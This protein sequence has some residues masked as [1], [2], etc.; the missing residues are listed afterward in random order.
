MGIS[1]F[2]I[3]VAEPVLEDLRSRLGETRWP[4]EIE[5]AGWD[6]GTHTAWLRELCEYWRDGYDWRRAESAL[7]GFAH[8]RVEVPG[9]TL[10]CIH[11]RSPHE[12]A[13]PLMLTHGWPDSVYLFHKI[14]GPLSRPEEY[15]GDAADAFHVVCPS[16]PGYGW[17]DAPRERG[18]HVRRVAEAQA[19]LMGRLGYR[20][21]GVQGGDW[22]AVISP[23]VALK[24]PD[25]VCGVHL[26]MVAA[27]P[28]TDREP[29]AETL[30]ALKRA[31]AHQQVGMGY[32]MIQGTKP[33]TLG[34]GLNDSPAG[35][36]AW[37]VEKYRAWSDC[38]GDV[39][40]VFTRDQLLTAVTIYWVTGTIT[41]SARLYYE[42]MRA[43]MFGP[44]TEYVPT[45]TGAAIFP[46][47]IF[48]PPRSWAERHYNITR[49]T[50]YPAGGH[51]AA[52]ER[53]DDLVDD[54]RAFYR[55][56]R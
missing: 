10:H 24:D 15:G 47:E 35:L 33:Q 32:A 9:L 12:D 46:R 23:W 7:N 3:A 54:I 29:D 11:E 1:D 5:Q 30:E 44:P 6:Y 39:E 42:S 14:I 28:P 4:E 36:A 41:S 2:R 18:W 53:P 13:L 26:N 49:W 55:P 31:R 40:S 48:L 27:R 8:L 37:I 34:V 22:G 20:R 25:R 16:I 38:G 51:F 21:Y 56:L 17:S 52:M 50:E 45:P 43:G 19:A